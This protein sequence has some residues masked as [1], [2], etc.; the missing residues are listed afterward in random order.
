MVFNNWFSK[1]NCFRVRLSNL[2][3][4]YYKIVVLSNFI[5]YP[6]NTYIVIE[7]Q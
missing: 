3:I 2:T 7:L 4:N 1:R 6:R 5:K